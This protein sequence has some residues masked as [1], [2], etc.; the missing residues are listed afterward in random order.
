MFLSQIYMLVLK[1]VL[2]FILYTIHK[3]SVNQLTHYVIFT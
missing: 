1:H 2:S 3:I